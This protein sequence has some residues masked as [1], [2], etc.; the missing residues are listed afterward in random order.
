MAY[1]TIH[2]TRDTIVTAVELTIHRVGHSISLFL[3]KGHK[4]SAQL[5]T[6]IRLI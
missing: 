5:L 2:L 3:L 6:A 4:L 1:D